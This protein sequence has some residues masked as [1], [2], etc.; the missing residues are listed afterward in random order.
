MEKLLDL[1]E[2]GLVPAPLN[3]GYL[4]GNY[5]FL[6]QEPKDR[7]FS[8][9]VFTSPMPAVVDE[10]N[11]KIYESNGIRPVIPRTSPLKTRIEASKLIFAAFSISEVIENFISC[12][13]TFNDCLR[14][15]IDCGN[16]ADQ[17]IFKV[18]AELQRIYGK[19]RVIIMAGN[20]GSPDTYI[21]YCR[22]EIDYVRIGLNNGSLVNENKYGFYYPTAS[23]IRD[24]KT[25][26]KTNCNGFP[27]KTKIIVDGGIESCADILKC[28]ALGADAVMIGRK[29]AEL[30]DAAGPLF[31]KANGKFE[32][33]D[34][35]MKEVKE[36]YR[37][38]EGNTIPQIRSRQDGYDN[39][40]DWLK[41]KTGR[42]KDST[43]EW[44]RIK[45]DLKTW[46]AEMYDTFSYGFMMANA[47]NW[48]TFQENIR[49]NII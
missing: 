45:K 46:M 43:A 9:P 21:Q 34:E 15:C 37:K 49:W 24:T 41:Q 29:F 44:V 47:Q 23:L 10:N 35:N 19:P 48:E 36:V 1:S 20:I 4:P 11:W 30:L 33:Y 31:V 26:Q 42:F 38:Y 17:E 32:P 5:N 3:S 14:I 25:K 40:H 28:I 8:L 6:I 2:I 13:Q 27:M 16:G 7:T 22:S 39:V 18:A 12:Q